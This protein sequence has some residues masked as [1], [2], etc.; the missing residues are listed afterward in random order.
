MNKERRLTRDHANVAELA[1]AADSKP[2]A[3]RRVGSIPTVGTRWVVHCKKEPFDVYIGRPSAFGNPFSEKAGT[4]AEVKVENR[5][6]A[7]A[8]FREWVSQQPE[9]VARIKRELRGKVLGCWCHPKACHGDVLAE[10]ANE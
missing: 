3:E 2:A 8:C 9:L 5:E 10:I 6:E 4:Q 1:D 7:I